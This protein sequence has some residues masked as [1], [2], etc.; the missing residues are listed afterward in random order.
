MTTSAPGA[1]PGGA[2]GATGVPTATHQ[3]GDLRGRRSMRYFRRLRA[4]TM[5]WIWLVPS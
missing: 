2:Q 5:R 1:L 3:A 4:I